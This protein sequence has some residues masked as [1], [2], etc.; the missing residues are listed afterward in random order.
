MAILKNVNSMNVTSMKKMKPKDKFPIPVMWYTRNGRNIRIVEMET[1]HLIN[2]MCMMERKFVTHYKSTEEAWKE[3]REHPTYIA[4][5]NEKARRD[6]RSVS[7]LDRM[8][9]AK[10]PKATPTTTV[11]DQEPEQDIEEEE[12]DLLDQFVGLDPADE[13]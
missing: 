2:A 5:L 7:V 11:M 6:P 10:L 4:L 9:V 13:V 8:R 12:D 1:S 3:L